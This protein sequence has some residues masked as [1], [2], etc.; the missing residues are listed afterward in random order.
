MLYSVLFSLQPTN[1]QIHIKIFFL[2][3]MFTATSFDTSVSS[4][5]SLKNFYF[6]KLQKF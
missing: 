2:Y 6:A 3:I 1:E 4:S 5:G